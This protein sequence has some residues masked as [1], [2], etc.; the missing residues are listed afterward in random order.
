MMYLRS[1]LR[2][3]NNVTWFKKVKIPWVKEK[4]KQKNKGIRTDPACVYLHNECT[5]KKLRKVVQEMH[6]TGRP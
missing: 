4:N 6:P 3:W 1:H 2:T 5:R